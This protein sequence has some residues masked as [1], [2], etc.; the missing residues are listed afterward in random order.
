MLSRTSDF[1]Q[2]LGKMD[3]QDYRL[4]ILAILAAPQGYKTLIRRLNLSAIYGR[5]VNSDLGKSTGFS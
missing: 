1:R 2:E 5:V 3:V 4:E